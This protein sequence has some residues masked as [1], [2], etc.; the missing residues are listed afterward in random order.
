MFNIFFRHKGS[1]CFYFFIMFVNINIL[2]IPNVRCLKFGSELFYF[3]FR[4]HKKRLYS[5]LNYLYST[6]LLNSN[7]SQRCTD[8]IFTTKPYY[9]YYDVLGESSWFNLPN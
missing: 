2:L 1:Y 6:E 4:T 8:K 7:S 9:C 3:I 5:F